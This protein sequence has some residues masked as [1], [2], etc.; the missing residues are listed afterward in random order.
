MS[1]FTLTI[2]GARGSMAVSGQERAQFGGATSCYMVRAG[3][4]TVF[5]DGGSGLIDAPAEFETVPA[6]LLS[7]LHLDH[8]LG[9]GMYARL[10][11]KG[12]R[13]D[14][15]VPAA[16]GED[17]SAVLD[18]VYSPPY[19]PLRLKEYA[20]D[21]RIFPFVTP[22]QIGDVLV[23]TMPGSHPGGCLV[24]K[25]TF[26]G[27]TLVYATDQEP[28]E[29]ALDRLAEFAKD[30]DLLMF[31]GQFTEEEAKAK[32][33]FGHSAPSIAIGL[34]KRCGAK[35]LLLIHHDPL[36]TDAELETA[37]K[38]TGLENVR[39]ARAGETVRI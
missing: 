24:M 16:E 2:L 14:L 1:S 7:H 8:I 28:D 3:K 9:L 4:Q 5:L 22:L 19:W 31:D 11:K 37:E 27:K 30:A 36:R 25:L 18:R 34:M 32:K 35:R 21:V 10:A 39:F 15:Y 23:E 6:I 13:T 12:L 29:E 17:A 26:E 33:G 20:G 38:M